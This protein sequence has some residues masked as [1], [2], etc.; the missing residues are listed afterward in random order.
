MKAFTALLLTILLLAGCT[1]PPAVT[2]QPPETTLAVPPETT[3]PP[4]TT[5]PSETTLPPETTVPLDPTEA[6]I[7][8]VVDAFLTAYEENVYLYTDNEYD[9]LTVL[10]ADPDA[11]VTWQGSTVPLSSFHKNIDF[12]HDKEAYW[13]YVRQ[14]QGITRHHYESTCHFDSIET[15]GDTATVKATL[16]ASWVY[17]DDPT[18]NGSGSF[19]EFELL[20]VRVKDTWLVADSLAI[21]DW[22]DAEYKNDPSFD[23][24]KLIAEFIPS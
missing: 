16:G 9:H 19:E 3:L 13:K 6:E 24:D 5:V 10:A 7:R 11:V 12:L 17:D 2:T 8:A 14:A 23:V 18:G 4:E 20:L 1:A 22:F 15:D 21:W